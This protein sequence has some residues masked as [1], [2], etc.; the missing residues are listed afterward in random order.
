MVIKIDEQDKEL[1][2]NHVIKTIEA[3]NS[4]TQRG[5]W[6]FKRPESGFYSMHI[7]FRPDTI[8]IYGDT[9]P[10]IIL[11]QNGID[12]PWL[13]G[14]IHSPSYLF[15]KS[16]IGNLAEYDQEE[17]EE[18]AKQLF[19]ERY[20]DAKERIGIGYVDWSDSHAAAEAIHE[21]DSDAHIIESYR[22]CAILWAGLLRF[23]ELM[24]N[25]SVDSVLS[26]PDDAEGRG[27]ASP[28]LDSREPSP[29]SRGSVR[30]GSVTLPLR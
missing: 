25:P 2:T 22:H 4:A 8:I 26:R 19:E 9:Q 23:C 1:F 13:L 5:E 20:P 24:K 17:T 16:A 12:L 29:I 30:A 27:D 11:R 14:S 28:R 15:S 6:I 18:Y 21:M 10:N 7:L 3:W